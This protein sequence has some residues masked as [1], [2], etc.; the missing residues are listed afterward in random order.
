MLSWTCS[1]SARVVTFYTDLD[2]ISFTLEPGDEKDFVILAGKDSCYTRI[3][4]LRGTQLVHETQ[5]VFMQARVWLWLLVM[6]TIVAAI[7]LRY[8]RK[9]RLPGLLSLGIWIPVLFW[10]GTVVAGFIHGDYNHFTQVVSEATAKAASMTKEATAKV[11]ET[12][13]RAA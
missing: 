12:A 11:A 1:D 2:S 4:T 8:R 9:F 13:K 6:V 10:A 3:S 5:C 7:S